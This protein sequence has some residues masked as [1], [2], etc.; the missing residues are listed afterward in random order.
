M[1]SEDEARLA[2]PLIVEEM[3]RILNEKICMDQHPHAMDFWK[4]SKQH[5]HRHEL[6]MY[7]GG[8]GWYVYFYRYGWCGIGPGTMTHTELA[9][10]ILWEWEKHESRI[11][12]G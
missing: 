6:T 4:L 12:S 1:L 7:Y 10:K 2:M 8:S 9:R 5:D 11:S 3:S